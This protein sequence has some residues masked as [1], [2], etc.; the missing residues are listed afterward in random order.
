MGV[1]SR[2]AG[3]KRKRIILIYML[4]VVVPGFVLGFLAFQGIRGGDALREKQVRQELNLAAQDFFRL[5]NREI[6]DWT[7]DTTF[8]PLVFIKDSGLHIVKDQMLYHPD[9]L[10]ELHDE[11]LAQPDRGWELEFIDNDLDGATRYYLDKMGSGY[12]NPEAVKAGIALARI[13][14]KQGRTREA[15]DEYQKILQSGVKE[16][17]GQLPVNLIAAIEILKIKAASGDTADLSAGMEKFAGILLNPDEGYGSRTFELFYSELKK[18]GNFLPGSDSLFSK[19]D[20]AVPRTEYLNKFLLTAADYLT[21]PGEQQVYLQKNGY[22]DLLVTKLLPNGTVRVAMVDLNFFL[23]QRLDSLV[24]EADP[25]R[26]YS[27]RITDENGIELF[28]SIR[29]TGNSLLTFPFPLPL[30][31]WKT[32]LQINPKPILPSIFESGK[33]LYTGIFALI[34][35]W[36][37]LGL[38]FT[39]YLLN[40]EIRLSRMKSR[41]ISNVSHEFK[42]PVTSIRHM[43]ELLRLRRVRTEEKKDE[44]YDSMIEQCDHLNHLVENI[45]DFSKIEDEIKKYRFEIVNLVELVQGLVDIYRNRHAESGMQIN[46]SASKN[47][48]MILADQDALRQVIYNLL[49]NVE[50]YASD[51]MRIDINLSLKTNDVC[52]EVRDYGRGIALADQQRIFDRFYRVDDKK[53]EGIKGSGIGLTLVKNIVESHQGSIELK[54]EPGNGSSFLVY[55]PIDQKF[56]K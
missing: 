46:F 34:A 47:I 32:D 52:M 39:I 2:P 50:K 54:S 27:W 53:N 31:G 1:K 18:L 22:R 10:H 28:N 6:S 13:L 33:V 41:F 45:L 43:S 38:I 7:V 25:D 12:K 24:S 16:N 19:I 48:P 56:K 15:I 5:F 30:P 29:P 17:I 37:V 21:Y 35:L 4:G 26:N 8:S 40:Q 14:K 20:R 42:S 11:I 36:L 3:S 44:F 55:L 23:H 9:G 49:D 51:G